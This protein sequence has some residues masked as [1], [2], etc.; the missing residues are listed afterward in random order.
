MNGLSMATGRRHSQV[1]EQSPSLEFED[2]SYR[3]KVL[4]TFPVN[5]DGQTSPTLPASPRPVG[6]LDHQ[7]LDDSQDEHNVL[8]L[9]TGGTIGMKAGKGGTCNCTAISLVGP[10]GHASVVK[11]FL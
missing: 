5:D 11:T 3:E 1:L 2:P 6:S 9:Y 8:V 7:G 4:K 10:I